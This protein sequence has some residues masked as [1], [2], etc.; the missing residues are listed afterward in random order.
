M[1]VTGEGI[2]SFPLI[3]WGL[4]TKSEARGTLAAASR[5]RGVDGWPFRLGGGWLQKEVKTR[6]WTPPFPTSSQQVGSGEVPPSLF[7]P[8]PPPPPDGSPPLP[9]ADCRCLAFLV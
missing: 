8:P 3:H 1:K 9:P 6:K 7:T 5:W 2:S 4:H